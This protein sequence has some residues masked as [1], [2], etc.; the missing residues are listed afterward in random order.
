VS[1]LVTLRAGIYHDSVTLMRIS[2]ALTE[3]PGVE[4]AIV[5]MA[6]ELNRA[7]AEDLGFTLPPSDQA[8]LLVAVRGPDL[9]GAEAELDRLLAARPAPGADPGEQPPLTTRSAARKGGDIV[10]V[11]V[12]GEHAFAEAVDAIEAGL[13]VMV[14][15]DGVP[16]EQEIVL[17][18]L[19][20]R[21]GVLVMGPDC[22]TA[23]IAGAGLG[24]ANVLR[25]GPVGVVAAS[26]TGAQQLTCLL[27]LAGVG[28][29]HVLGVGGRDLTPE[30]G[31]RSSARA[32][33]MLEEDP[34]TEL[35]ALVA[36]Q[37][38]VDLREPGKRFVRA[39]IDLTEAAEEVLRAL[40]RAVPE[41]PSW[42]G[43]SGRAGGA[44]S[45]TLR[46][47]YAGGTLCGEA[48]ALA[49]TGEFTDYGD[50][51]YT[52]GRPH[53]MIDPTLRLEALAQVAAGDVV[54][55]DVVLGHGADPDP[56]AAYAHGIARCPA[57]VVVAL[58]GTEG[59]P[60][61]LHRQ[62]AALREAGASVFT[63]NAQAAR[64]ARSLL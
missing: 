18:E 43:W 29:S 19:A 9:S 27:D 8:D 24:F 51:A 39:G 38:S 12:P 50:D 62:A 16:V 17:K 63:S 26:G 22:G 54:L 52:R 57:T 41:W 42:P 5:S 13:P 44:P 21:K 45:G 36:K 40:G 6:T 48:A 30:V 46:G 3:L 14:F 35:I 7:L 56:A 28:V 1:E 47:L 53:P 23:V 33:R 58:V 37:P 31:G 59:D 25:P 20:E 55:M 10:L 2:R 61:D 34:A 32:L 15:S 4:V 64:Y 49:G 11:S 60:Q